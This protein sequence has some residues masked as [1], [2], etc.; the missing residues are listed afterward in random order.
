M[1]AQ[2][3]GALEHGVV[4]L[5]LPIGLVYLGNEGGE[6]GRAGSIVIEERAELA[7]QQRM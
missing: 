6:L 7:V 5:K 2:L 1:R 3:E 4:A